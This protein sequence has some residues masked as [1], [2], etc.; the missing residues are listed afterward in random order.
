DSRPG[1]IGG[2]G[3]KGGL[4]AARDAAVLKTVYAFGLRRAETAMLDLVDLRRNPTMPH[5]RQF[6]S[7]LVRYGKASNG[8]APK[9]R[10]VLL[11]PEVEWITDTLDDWLP[12]LRP[13]FS[14]GKHP[15][16]WVTERAGRLSRRSINEA[17]VA[18]RRDADL[19]EN[20]DVHSL[21]HS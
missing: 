1:R 19:D 7:V 13:R 2:R 20:L 16:L 15:A 3:V 21:R 6:G 4:S 18:A 11:V 8:T 12:D 10:S 5:F 14:P 9:R 17:F